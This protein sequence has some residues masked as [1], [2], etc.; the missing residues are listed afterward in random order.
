MK[1]HKLLLTGIIPVGMPAMTL[2]FVLALAGCGDSPGGE[3]RF[4]SRTSL[5][6]NA[7]LSLGIYGSAVTSGDEAV[8][9]ARITDDNITLTS[10]GAGTTTIYAVNGASREAIMTV[11]V[12]A[13]GN[14]SNVAFLKGQ[15]T[16]LIDNAAYGLGIIGTAAKSNDPNVANVEIRGDKVQIT[17]MGA[18]LASITV[19]GPDDKADAVIEVK[20]TPTGDILLGPIAKGGEEVIKISGTVGGVTVGGERRPVTLRVNFNWEGVQVNPDEQG[21]WYVKHAPFD[22]ETPLWMELYIAVVG[23]GEGIPALT[24]RSINYQIS[25][26]RMVKDAS[27]SGLVVPPV[28]IPNLITISGMVDAPLTGTWDRENKQVQVMA[29]NRDIQE[30][31]AEPGWLNASAY[32]AADGRWEMSVPSSEEET[33]VT[34]TVRHVASGPSPHWAYL[35]IWDAGQKTNLAPGT[36]LRNENVPD[37]DLGTIPFV[38]VRGNTPVTVNGDT[39]YKYYIDFGDYGR[40]NANGWSGETSWLAA[41]TGGAWAVPMP[42]GISLEA[43]IVYCEKS[44]MQRGRSWSV[45]FNTDDNLSNIDLSTIST[46]IK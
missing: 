19:I 14:I 24:D 21:R 5:I 42:Q 23:T 44:F 40:D 22:Q 25:E 46:I 10:Q 6:E 11:T 34:F 9:T 37:I 30:L 27:I 29:V 28:D 38:M 39:P 13:D 32:V 45:P 17:P 8:V 2:A 35:D 12:A 36:V 16:L 4:S 15:K 18:G 41:A 31:G 33:Q 1:H 26:Q 43:T 20:V 7:V 3:N